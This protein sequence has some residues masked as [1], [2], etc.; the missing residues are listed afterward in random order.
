MPQ[1]L[2][3]EGQ[4]TNGHKRAGPTRKRLA[5]CWFSEK[6]SLSLRVGL[7]CVCVYTK[8]AHT[9]IFSNVS[10]N[11]FTRANIPHAGGHIE[12][13]AAN[14]GGRSRRRLSVGYVCVKFH[15]FVTVRL[16]RFCKVNNKSAYYGNGFLRT[17]CPRNSRK[18][19]EKFTQALQDSQYQAFAEFL[20]FF[21][22]L[23][24]FSLIFPDFSVSPVLSFCI[25]A[26]QWHVVIA[27]TATFS[28]AEKRNP[29]EKTKDAYNVAAFWIPRL[30]AE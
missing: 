29:E 8:I 16:M 21:V 9:Q 30:G 10:A 24:M 13:A 17:C 28:S 26:A 5:G 11:I 7:M 3:G 1:A 27:L 2:T 14:A 22:V 20:F 4:G 18:V 25:S 12:A 15:R 23:L 6:I 19:S